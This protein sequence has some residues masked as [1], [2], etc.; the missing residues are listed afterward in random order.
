MSLISSVRKQFLL[1]YPTC[2]F[3]NITIIFAYKNIILGIPCKNLYIW[4]Y[5]TMLSYHYTIKD[6]TIQLQKQDQVQKD[7][8]V[9]NIKIK[10]EGNHLEY[11]CNDS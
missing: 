9:H 5:L 7:S 3:L 2:I 6:S 4:V 11:Q 1:K 8:T 10:K